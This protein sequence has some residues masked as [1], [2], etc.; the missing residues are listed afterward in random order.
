MFSKDYKLYKVVFI[1]CKTLSN[2]NIILCIIVV[3]GNAIKRIINAMC[4]LKGKLTAAILSKQLVC[5]FIN[6]RPVIVIN[7]S[8]NINKVGLFI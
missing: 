4:I 3:I 8:V 5:Y 6:S 2:V 1:F 7:R